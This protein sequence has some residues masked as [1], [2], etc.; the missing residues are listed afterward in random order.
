MKQIIKIKKINNPMSEFSFSRLLLI[1]AILI[2]IFGLLYIRKEIIEKFNELNGPDNNDNFSIEVSNDVSKVEKIWEHQFPSGKVV[3]FWKHKSLEDEEYYPMGH[4]ITVGD[5]IINEQKLQD[6]ESIKLLATRGAHP[7]DYRKIW[8]S[9]ELNPPPR[10]PLSIWKPIPPSGYIALGDVAHNDLEEPSINTIMCVPINCLT[11][12]SIKKREFKYEPRKEEEH[13]SI[14]NVSNRGFFFANDSVDKP[15]IRE[16]NAYD[17]S[18][19]CLKSSRQ[20]DPNES[21]KSITLFI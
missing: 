17:I 13:L 14:W 18:D 21:K 11:K 12:S 2:A 4:V 7:I 10:T 9:S 1:L 19:E 5:K 8:D 16:K 6:I 15:E 20:L 3:V